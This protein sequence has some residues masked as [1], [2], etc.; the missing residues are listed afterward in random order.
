FV[1]FQSSATNLVP[2]DT[3]A[4][5]DILVR[6]RGT[7]PDVQLSVSDAQVSEGSAKASRA[8]AF[9][10]ELSAITSQ[11]VTF[12]FSTEDVSARAGSDYQ[13]IF[14]TATIRAGLQSTTI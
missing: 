1:A 7:I 9:T 13:P 4:A 10:V 2:A 3:N 5:G 14:G 11:N 6:D 8:L 12:R